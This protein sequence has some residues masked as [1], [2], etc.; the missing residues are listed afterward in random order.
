[1]YS[2]LVVP[3]GEDK[4]CVTG[5]RKWNSLLVLAGSG[6]TAGHRKVTHF[7]VRS[8]TSRKAP[9]DIVLFIRSSVFPHILAR[10]PLDGFM[11]NL[12]LKTYTKIWGEIPYSVE[13]KQVYRGTLLEDLSTYFCLVENSTK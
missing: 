3:L 11:W 10:L 6:K 1:M 13:T 7:N 5:R 12:I 4:L 9:I 8:L 2:V